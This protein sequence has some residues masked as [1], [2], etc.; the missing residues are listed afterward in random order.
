MPLLGG[1][2]VYIYIQSKRFILTEVQ[3]N[4]GVLY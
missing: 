2:P 4:E 3:I 1:L